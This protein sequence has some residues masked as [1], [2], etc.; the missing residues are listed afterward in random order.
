MPRGEFRMRTQPMGDVYRL[1]T[2]PTRIRELMP[3]MREDAMR[4]KMETQLRDFPRVYRM[5]GEH[6]KMLAPSRI[7]SPRGTLELRKRSGVRANETGRLTIEKEQ[8]A[9]AKADSLKK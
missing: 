2:S 4:G 1:R 7:R 8:K 6:F 9:K 5:N 3:L